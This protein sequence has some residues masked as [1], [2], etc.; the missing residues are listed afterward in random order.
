MT[1]PADDLTALL[2]GQITAGELAPGSK[3]PPV[4]E[5]IDRWGATERAVRTAYARLA[6]EGMVRASRGKGTIVVGVDLQQIPVDNG[7]H[8]DQLGYYFSKAAQ[9]FRLIGTPTITTITANLKIARLL[10]VDAGSPLVVRERVLGERGTK[11]TRP[12]PLQI[13]T[14]YLPGWLS[15]QLPIV[16]EPDTGP[17][18][19]LARIEEW[20]NGPLRWPRP[21]YGA[22]TATTDEAKALALP[23]GAALFVRYRVAVLPDG[24]PVELNVTRWDGGRFE[25]VLPELRRDASAGWPPDPAVE[26]P[27]VGD[28]EDGPE[29]ET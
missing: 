29:E 8:H 14:S 4:R 23:A 21:T 27:Q 11:R 28:T 20:V 16:A 7:V 10:D 6:A 13:A 15:E 24:R 5:A 17:G 12:T 26:S 25:L 3:L 22:A 9:D 2:R 19:I 18:G 1:Q